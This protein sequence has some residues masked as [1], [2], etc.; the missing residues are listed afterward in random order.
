MRRA[1]TAGAVVVVLMSVAA[2]AS[3]TDVTVA[4]LRELAR[5]AVEEP[6]ARNEL[7]SVTSVDGRSF[8]GEQLVGG[9]PESVTARLRALAREPSGQVDA[10]DART[11]AQQVLSQ[12]KFRPPDVPRPLRGI[13]T[14]IGDNLIRP[15]GDRI[16]SLFD[17]VA[18]RIPGGRVATW[19]LLGLLFAILVWV[20]ARR[21]SR[22][23]VA[24]ARERT[25]IALESSVDA[26]ELEREADLA[27]QGGELEAA[28]RLRFRAGLLKL[29]EL[30]VIEF[31][32]S[33]TSYEVARLLRSPDFDALA[34]SFDEIVYGR[35]AATRDDMQTSRR[36]W[37]R[38]LERSR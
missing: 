26:A 18:A 20:V 5:R 28:M 33:M 30:E 7:R 35:R 19:V 12:R 32:P 17:G 10:D 16:A 38:I 36:A 31:R 6:A 4:E 25:R 14:W 22:S 34:R 21:W 15:V 24:Q 1:L 11:D 9:P 3:A 8:D 2:P 23:Q 13:L 29:D 27:E 37:E